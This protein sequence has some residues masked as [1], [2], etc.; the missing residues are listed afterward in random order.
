MADLKKVRL[1]TLGVRIE[2]S[3]KERLKQSAEEKGISLSDFTRFLFSRI[4]GYSAEVIL[5]LAA[6]AK[7]VDRV[8]GESIDR[9]GKAMGANRQALDLIEKEKET[10][11][12]LKQQ[13]IELKSMNEAMRIGIRQ[14][15][16]KMETGEVQ[17]LVINMDQ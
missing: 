16:D 14:Q 9:I 15:Q 8:L 12:K 7:E 5:G 17:P 2:K 4:T 3:L 6:E 11:Q 1:E 13:W 10:Y